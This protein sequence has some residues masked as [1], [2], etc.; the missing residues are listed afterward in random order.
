[1]ITR[2]PML[3]SRFEPTVKETFLTGFRL[4]EKPGLLADLGCNT[5]HALCYAAMHGWI[6]H[7][8]DVDS[9]V[10]AEANKLFRQHRITNVSAYCLSLQ[11]FL[12]QTPYM[13][14][15]VSSIDVL[16]F[17]P[18]KEMPEVLRRIGE[19]TKS[20]GIVQLRVFTPLEE[21]VTRGLGRTHFPKGQLVQAFPNFEIIEDLQ[22][23]LQD[24]GHVGR[25]E[26]HEHHVEVFVAKKQ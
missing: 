17:V 18:P 6:A 9:T 10:I 25:P 5:G 7:G 11:D 16:T 22:E 1:M 3:K 8:C 21:I 2:Q 24:P 20:Q 26:P 13:Y 14:D 23:V 19:V 12:R 15:F 4:F